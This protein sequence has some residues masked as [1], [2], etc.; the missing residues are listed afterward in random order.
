MTEIRV[1]YFIELVCA[2]GFLKE[3]VWGYDTWKDACAA[4][5]RFKKSGATKIV[6]RCERTMVTRRKYK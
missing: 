2:Q 4:C 1:T 6:I 3:S 5:R